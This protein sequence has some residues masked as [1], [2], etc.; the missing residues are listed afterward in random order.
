MRRIQSTPVFPDL[1]DKRMDAELTE[2]SLERDMTQP[3]FRQ[4]LSNIQENL[5]ALASV[6]GEHLQNLPKPPEKVVSI[7]KEFRDFAFQGS[8]VDLSVGIIL[9]GAFGSVISSLV[10]DIIMPPIGWLLSGVDFA[11]IFV[12]LK[13]GKKNKITKG[14]YKSLGQAKDDGAVTVNIGVFLN[15]VL[16]F[17]VIAVIIFT[18]VRT[19]NK[20]KRQDV[21]K[22]KCEFCYSKIDCR[23]TKCA[24]CTSDVTPTSP[25]NLDQIGADNDEEGKSTSKYLKKR[26]KKQ[27]SKSSLIMHS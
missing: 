5:E 23:A 2:G 10:N 6:A 22:K 20:V 24:Y 25:P 12:L 1:V 9:G 17:V 18:F 8:V 27:F 15:S 19:I 26:L 16:N 21:A 14:I 13:R 4:S 11:N 7:W 3:V